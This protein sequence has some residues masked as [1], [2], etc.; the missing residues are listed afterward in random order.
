LTFNGLQ[1]IVS[2]TILHFIANA[3][4]TSN[5]TSK[6]LLAV[7]FVLVSSLAYTST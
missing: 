7:R 5:P 1:D 6:S 3:M 2:Q 4:T